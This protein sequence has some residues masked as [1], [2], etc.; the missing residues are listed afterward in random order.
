MVIVNAD[1]DNYYLIYTNKMY[2][3]H[4]NHGNI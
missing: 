3:T 4:L 2:S 1:M